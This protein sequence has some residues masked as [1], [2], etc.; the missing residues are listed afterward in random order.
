MSENK[1]FIIFDLNGVIVDD[2][3][4][5]KKAWDLFCLKHNF[6]LTKTDLNQHVY[7]KI[8]SEIFQFL[9]GKKLKKS[10][11]EKYT[12][13]K[14]SL[15]RNAFKKHLKPTKGLIAFLKKLERKKIILAIATSAPPKNV[16]FVLTRLKIKKF[17]SLILDDTSIKK[18]KP[19]P[20]I[21]L[22]T[23]KK[24]KARPSQCIVFE[25]S[26]SGIEAAK[27]AGMK[28]IAIATTHRKKEIKIADLV[29]DSFNDIKFDHLSALIN[30]N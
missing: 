27:R 29:I 17:F 10:L 15:Y 30:K 5:H 28:V 6:K 16:D 22:K 8:N 24:I 25:D 4:W 3:Q 23:A 11:L 9:F 1:F 2:S 19:H 7:G 20:E 14:E 13:E 18:G 26:L 12:A 21:Y